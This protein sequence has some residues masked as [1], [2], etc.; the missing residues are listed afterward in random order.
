M[1]LEKEISQAGCT[2]S[3][4]GNKILKS[5]LDGIGFVSDFLDDKDTELDP[6][7][8]SARLHMLSLEVSTAAHVLLQDDPLAT[9]LAAINRSSFTPDCEPY[10]MQLI[11]FAVEDCCSE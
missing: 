9:T 7:Y 11:E 5:F 4:S 1:A 10:I 3:Q 8:V 6:A 2:D